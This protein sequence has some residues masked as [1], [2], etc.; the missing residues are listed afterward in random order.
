MTLRQLTSRAFKWPVLW[1]VAMWYALRQ[2]HD[3]MLGTCLPCAAHARRLRDGH[4][5]TIGNGMVVC[6]KCALAFPWPTW[7]CK[8]SRPQNPKLNEPRRLPGIPVFWD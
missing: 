4:V 7:K 8:G 1:R 5:A 6:R 3:E 2:E